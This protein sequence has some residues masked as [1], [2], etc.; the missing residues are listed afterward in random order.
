MCLFLWW[1]VSSAEN[2]SRSGWEVLLSSPLCPCGY[3]A[4]LFGA[5]FQIFSSGF[6]YSDINH[7]ISRN[8]GDDDDDD[9]FS[10]LSSCGAVGAEPFSLEIRGLG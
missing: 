5:S 9:Y 2:I 4:V 7:L 8:I 10:P 1:R 6:E 3:R